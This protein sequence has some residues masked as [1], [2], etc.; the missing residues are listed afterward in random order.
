MQTAYQ[1]GKGYLTEMLENKDDETLAETPNLEKVSSN[2]NTKK[3]TK[4]T[5]V[6]N[7]K[8]KKIKKLEQD[9]VKIQR[10]S[11]KKVIIKMIFQKKI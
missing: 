11:S 7:Q 5:S 10:T 2:P 3:K 6:Q 1:V 8:K 4:L 9:S